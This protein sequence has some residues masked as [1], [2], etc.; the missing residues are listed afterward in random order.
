MKILCFKVEETHFATRKALPEHEL[1]IA[2]VF[3]IQEVLSILSCQGCKGPA[4][5][6]TCR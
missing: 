2:Q 3:A 1:F 5:M 6:P 4:L